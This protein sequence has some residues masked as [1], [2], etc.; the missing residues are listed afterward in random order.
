MLV[1]KELSCRESF[2]MI[3]NLEYQI[4]A[5]IQHLEKEYGATV[6][7][8]KKT[9]LT[10]EEKMTIV[11]GLSQLHDSIKGVLA[12]T[13]LPSNKEN[14][15]IEDRDDSLWSTYNLVNEALRHHGR[16]KVLEDGTVEGVS[17]FEKNETLMDDMRGEAAKAA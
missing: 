2:A 4:A 16:T 8:M 1:S 3:P 6:D 9:M 10:Y 14:L 5:T 11:T 13:L 7:E 15:R 17:E 12:K